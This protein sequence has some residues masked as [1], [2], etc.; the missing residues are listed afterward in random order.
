MDIYIHQVIQINV[1]PPEN[2]KD[3]FTTLEGTFTCGNT[4]LTIPAFCKGE[5]KWAI[6]FSPICIGIW[7]Y[8]LPNGDTGTLNCI[9]NES[10]YLVPL[11][12]ENINGRQIFVES[13][14]K[15]HFQ[16]TYECDW[17]FALWMAN[18]ED[19]KILIRKICENKFNGVVFNFYA[20]E[21][22]WTDP[23]TSGR[24]VPPI[25]YIW[26]GNN[27]A[28]DFDALNETFYSELDELFYY[29][30]EKQ[31]YAYVYYFVYNKNV[32]YP[33]Q[34]SSQER[35]YIQQT[36]AR[37]Q[38][39]PNIIWVYGKE[40]YLNPEKEVI[41]ENLEFIRKTDAYKRLLTFQDDKKLMQSKRAMDVTDFHMIQ[42]HT[43]FYEYTRNLAWNSDRPLFHSE[44]GYE[45]GASLDDITYN[46]AQEVREFLMR[47]WTVAFAGAGICYYYTYTGWDVIRPYDNPQGYVMFKTLNEYFQNFDWWNFVPRADLMLWTPGHCLKH[48]DRED[49]VFITNHRGKIL[50]D[51]EIGKT[52]FKGSWL[53]PFTGESVPLTSEH[54][55]MSEC[56]DFATILTS[57]FE[58]ND[59]DDYAIVRVSIS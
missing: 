15:P 42:Q 28:P 52:T 44:F 2:T 7:N 53:N 45:S 6:H 37:Y 55:Q 38:A 19:A 8:T 12:T 1:T 47:A 5:G 59:R 39:F 31:L 30:Q 9:A 17:L 11:R 20:H 49:F 27:E 10:S 24:L 26:K 54:L 21:C 46:E 56:N 36:C 41:V 48:K 4:S 16:T 57:P 35:M 34:G 14:N 58:K 32:S 25:K 22:T 43:D 50:M 33:K 18:R 40:V 51:Y 23:N 13:V 3:Y 29:L